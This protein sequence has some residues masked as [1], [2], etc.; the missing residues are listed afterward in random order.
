MIEKWRAN[1]VEWELCDEISLSCRHNIKQF[2][3]L[4]LSWLHRLMRHC[5]IEIGH[6]FWHR[7][8]GLIKHDLMWCR[9]MREGMLRYVKVSQLSVHKAYSLLLLCWFI[10]LFESLVSCTAQYIEIL[11]KYS[12]KF[13]TNVRMYQIYV[14][15]EQDFNIYHTPSFILLSLQYISFDPNILV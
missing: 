15:F 14:N 5:D 7:N 8:L 13:K 11:K 3:K 9:W 6:L 10:C 1:V 2:L 4:D 12:L